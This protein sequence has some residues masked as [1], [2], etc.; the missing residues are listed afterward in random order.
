VERAA[1]AEGRALKRAAAL[2]VI[3]CAIACKKAPPPTDADAENAGAARLR[4]CE[5]GDFQTCFAAGLAALRARDV[6]SARRAYMAACSHGSEFDGGTE[7]CV[8]DVTRALDP[9]ASAHDDCVAKKLGG[10]RREGELLIALRVDAP[11]E[12]E[13]KLRALA[14]SDGTFG[15]CVT[16]MH[17]IAYCEAKAMELLAKNPPPDRARCEKAGLFTAASTA[18][19]RDVGTDAD[20]RAPDAGDAGVKTREHPTIVGPATIESITHDL[21]REVVTAELA[22]VMP[23]IAACANGAE[24][25]ATN[26]PLR[27]AFG[28]DPFGEVP[29]AHFIGWPTGDVRIYACVLEI[30]RSLRFAK[31]DEAPIASAKD[32]EAPR[33][34]RNAAV[35]I[36]LTTRNAP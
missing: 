3:A 2:V 29:L 17:E 31:A 4:A 5:G 15:A 23:D 35:D 10:C 25:F 1:G 28:V 19:A 22:R 8:A 27:I 16:S 12:E 24:P 7:A 20:A 26:D 9:L 6:A 13:C 33:V 32:A 11:F 36:S 14:S 34:T 30:V 21:E 18:S